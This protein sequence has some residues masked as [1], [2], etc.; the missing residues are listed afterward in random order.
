MRPFLI[1]PLDEYLNIIP[2]KK[3][4]DNPINPLKFKFIFVYF[5]II[6]STNDK[7]AKII[8]INII[9]YNPI[10]VDEGAYQAG[11][12]DIERFGAGL[13][14]FDGL[15][16]VV[17]RRH[18]LTQAFKQPLFGRTDSFIVVHQQD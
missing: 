7:N 8:R 18:L 11:D 14:Q 13:D 10:A 15:P 3:F 12:N 16:A 6:I 4:L 2:G 1:C 17:H 9:S 5:K